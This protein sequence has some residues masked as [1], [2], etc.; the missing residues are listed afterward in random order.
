MS[1]SNKDNNNFDNEIDTN[2]ISI[3]AITI[4][5]FSD[6]YVEKKSVTFYDLK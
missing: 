4:K 6:R 3:I 2:L 1:S 5:S